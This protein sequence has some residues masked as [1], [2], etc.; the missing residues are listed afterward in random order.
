[1]DQYYDYALPEEEDWN[2]LIEQDQE[3]MEVAR[4]TKELEEKG[5]IE[6]PRM[7]LINAALP[8]LTNL[9][10]FNLDED[11]DMDTLKQ[12]FNINDENNDE[13][14]PLFVSNEKR[15]KV[16][17][18]NKYSEAP[19]LAVARSRPI[20]QHTSPTQQKSVDYTKRPLTGQY[21][22]ARCP[23]TDKILYYP[24]VEQPKSA[25]ATEMKSSMRHMNLLK[26]PV[27]KMLEEIE[28]E[29]QRKHDQGQKRLRDDKA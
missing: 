10:V 23:F 3:E 20:V 5:N 15:L 16:N 7:F 1:M 26:K 25:P 4:L 2:A 28:L 22:E 18:D 27:W 29:K 11:M 21:L 19:G 14:L 17:T 9:L 13:D 12:S 24:K 8:W 6:E